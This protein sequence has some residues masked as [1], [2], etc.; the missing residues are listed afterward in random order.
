M[1]INLVLTTNYFP[2]T[3]IEIFLCLQKL[4][5]AIILAKCKL[6]TVKDGA[7]KSSLLENISKGTA[8]K[9]V[10]AS[11]LSRLHI[12]DPYRF[13]K[14]ET[15][16]TYTKEYHLWYT[17]WENYFDSLNEIEIG[18]IEKAFINGEDLSEWRPEGTGERNS[19]RLA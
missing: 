18:E 12:L 1:Q 9:D 14:A 3:E 11:D 19:L 5:Q 8:Q 7:L 13:N 17:W 16:L 6:E 4:T 15:T 10:V 2:N